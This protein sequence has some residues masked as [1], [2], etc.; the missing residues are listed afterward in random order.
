M[1]KKPRRVSRPQARKR[2]DWFSAATCAPSRGASLAH[3]GAIHLLAENTLRGASVELSAFSGQPRRRA[4]RIL[5]EKVAQPLFR[6]SQA[7]PA[8]GAFSVSGARARHAWQTCVAH[9]TTIDTMASG[10][11]CCQPTKRRQNDGIWPAHC[12]FKRRDFSRCD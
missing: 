3:C 9:M 1:S 2:Y 12:R 10:D 7:P 6:Q 11:K 8:G 5:L 4:K